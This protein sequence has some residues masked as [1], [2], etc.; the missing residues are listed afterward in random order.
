MADSGIVRF[1]GDFTAEVTISEAHVDELTIAN[2]PVERG[3][4]ITDHAFKEPAQLTIKAGWSA[5]YAATADTG[6]D[7][8][9]GDDSGTGQGLNDLY[10]QLLLAQSGVELIEVQTGKRLYENMLIKSLQ[11]TTDPATENVLMLTAQLREVILVDTL[12]V[13]MPSNDD[14]ADPAATSGIADKG[15]KTPVPYTAPLPDSVGVPDDG[16]AQ[17]FEIPLTP[18]A[19]SFSTTIAGQVVNMAMQWSNAP[20]GGWMMNIADA[21]GNAL[22]NGL[23]LVTGGDILGQ[24]KDIGIDAA[25]HVVNSAGGDLAPTFENLGVDT[26]LIFLPS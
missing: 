10:T 2:H 8:T 18:E 5:A 4:S 1:M 22:A 20:E 12:A 9:E 25:M 11:V 19:Q 15:T 3:A 21:A 16:S 26:H 13:T 7:G 24:L 17:A 14:R 23:P 6:G